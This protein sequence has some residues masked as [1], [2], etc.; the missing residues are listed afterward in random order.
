[1]FLVTRTF[2][3]AVVNAERSLLPFPMGDV[4]VSASTP[5]S[6]HRFSA[7]RRFRTSDVLRGWLRT[8]SS[9]LQ[10]SLRIW[11]I[12]AYLNVA[13]LCLP[14][15][16]TGVCFQCHLEFESRSLAAIHC[17]PPSSSVGLH[18]FLPG[19]LSVRWWNSNFINNWTLLILFILFNDCG[20]LQMHWMYGCV[21]E[22]CMRY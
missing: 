5:D 13:F 19:N 17:N 15:M 11:L 2:L 16:F 4:W 6:W 8:Y 10:A 12:L 7:S 14:V 20:N 21:F 22:K 1:M 3:A 9:L 18:V